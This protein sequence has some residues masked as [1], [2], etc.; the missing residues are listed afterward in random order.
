MLPS[1]RLFS[2][3]LLTL[4][5]CISPGAFAQLEEGVAKK[6]IAA[7]TAGSGLPGNTLPALVL[8]A[9]GQADYIELDLVATSD[10]RLLVF[11][12]I[13]LGPT[14]NVADIFP[15]RARE[16]GSFPCLDFTLEEIRQL[17]YRSTNQGPYPAPQPGIP[18]FAEYLSL[19]R[20]LEKQL[21]IQIGLV[22]DIL[23]P[24]FHR[25]HQVDISNLTLQ[26][27]HGYGYGRGNDDLLL[28]SLDG[29]ELQRI[30]KELLPMLMM[31]IPLYQRIGQR[32]QE[33]ARDNTVP[34][35]DHSWMLTR[36]GTRLLAS[37]ASGIVIHTSL[38]HDGK[39]APLNEQFLENIRTLGLTIAG[40]PI[41]NNPAG[42]PEFAQN[43]P[44]LLDFY[45]DELALDAIL[46][47]AVSECIEYFEA[48]EK[49][50]AAP[51]LPLFPLQPLTTE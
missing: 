11:G 47:D 5:L 3:V 31:D 41:S 43:L 8:N 23:H 1:A 24:A 45:F 49:E 6:I 33:T 18:T 19:V 12:D 9:T 15:A 36:I 38:L 10:R 46:T 50:A 35:Y 7:S 42:P 51:S 22:I 26:Q 13:D 37:Y 21:Q 39:G 34:V 14:T 29:D 28:E 44:A 20:H 27:L 40:F 17:R 25:K 32:P 2:A 30:K 16:D 48:K 4:T